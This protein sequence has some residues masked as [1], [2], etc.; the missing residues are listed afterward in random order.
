[1]SKVAPTLSAAW[2]TKGKNPLALLMPVAEEVE[3]S[4]P[5]HWELDLP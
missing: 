5:S 2:L 1:M 3:P 4:P